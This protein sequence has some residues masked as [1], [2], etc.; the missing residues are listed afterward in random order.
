[1]IADQCPMSGSFSGSKD[2]NMGPAPHDRGWEQHHSRRSIIGP[3]RRLAPIKEMDYG[4]KSSAFRMV[5]RWSCRLGLDTRFGS[6]RGIQTGSGSLPA[7]SHPHTARKRPFGQRTEGVRGV[8]RRSCSPVSLNSRQ[9]SPAMASGD[10]RPIRCG[11]RLAGT[12][13][14][15]RGQTGRWPGN[16]RPDIPDKSSGSRRQ[17]RVP[18]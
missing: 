16:P 3:D 5:R 14:P 18:P 9:A 15:R 8:L 6:R 10:F 7:V 1:V 13:P 12:C 11:L 17:R 2:K 4:R